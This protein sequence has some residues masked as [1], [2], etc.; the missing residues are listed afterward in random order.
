MMTSRL[1]RAIAALS[2]LDYAVSGATLVYGFYS[3]Q[4]LYVLLGMAGM[5]IAV[6]NPAERIRKW[7]TAK[8][9]RRQESR[10]AAG[11]NEATP[12]FVPSGDNK[13]VPAHSA[14]AYKPKSRYAS[15]RYTFKPLTP[16]TT[17]L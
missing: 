4:Q 15:T 14:L 6:L 10:A 7:A 11:A 1:T 5:G 9:T 17:S 12:A 3:G 2:Y 8:L 16:T 13:P